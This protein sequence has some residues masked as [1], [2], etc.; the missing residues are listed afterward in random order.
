[1]INPPHTTH[2]ES[3]TAN[4]GLS[5][6]LTTSSVTQMSFQHCESLGLWSPHPSHID[7]VRD[8]YTVSAPINVPPLV[9]PPSQ[10]CHWLAA[11]MSS[12]TGG[13]QGCPGLQRLTASRL[14]DWSQAATIKK[15]A[16]PSLPFRRLRARGDRTGPDKTHTACSGTCRGGGGEASGNNKSTESE[17]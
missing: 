3:T 5:S 1:M 17:R 10:R 8:I 11:V 6:H 4:V 14:C 15:K 2:P 7:L 12:V 13:Q 9:T 16:A